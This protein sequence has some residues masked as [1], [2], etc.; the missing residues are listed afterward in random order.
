MAIIQSR[1]QK[2]QTGA[3]YTD[4]RKRKKHE[5]GRSPT[6]T[7]VG[8]VKRKSTRVLGGNQKIFT[9]NT[10]T[11]NLVGKDGKTKKV[12]IK[13][14]VENEANRNY[15]RRNILTKGTIIETDGG[16]A[17]ITSR[18]GQEGVINAVLVK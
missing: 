3:K 11:V 5:L 12:K 4:F 1:P 7:K 8:E 17:K 2:K 15:V 10:D 9:L 18:P 16:K 6:L 13:A 14:V